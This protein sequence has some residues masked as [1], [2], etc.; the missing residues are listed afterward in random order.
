[1]TT[2]A[3]WSV[4]HHGAGSP[5]IPHGAG[6]RRPGLPVRSRH[7]VRAVVRQPEDAYVPAEPRLLPTREPTSG[8]DRQIPRLRLADLTIEEALHL[9]V[10][11]RAR[12]G[13]ALTKAGAG[14][15]AHLF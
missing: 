13:H 14:E 10:P 11:Q 12:G 8:S 15:P 3:C 5:A 9:L 7:Q 4:F 6:P 1:M 2:C